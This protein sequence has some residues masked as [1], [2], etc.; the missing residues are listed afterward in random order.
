[1]TDVTRQK[2]VSS[3]TPSFIKR[4]VLSRLMTY[5]GSTHYQ[6]RLRKK[7][8]KRRL[9]ESRNHVVEY[10][11][12]VDDGYS[13]LAIQL[14]APLCSAYEID[15]IV[16]L[17]PALQDDNFP[18]PELLRELAR[19]DAMA[20]APYYNLA[21]PDSDALPTAEACNL[22][23]AIMCHLSNE[24]RIKLGPEVS[25]CL[26]RG[27]VDGLTSLAATHGSA[28]LA[29][30]QACL[31]AGTEHRA[32]L[33]HYSGAMFSYEGEWYWGVDRLH[34]LESRLAALNLRHS[35]V[36]TPLAPRR[37]LPRVYGPEASAL[38]LEFYP[39]LRS[40]YTAVAWHP[41]LQLAEQS[42]VTF[43][44]KPVLPMVMRGV[45]ATIPKAKYIFT[46]AA[47]EARSFGVDYG[48]FFD[49]IGKPVMQGYSLYMWAITQNKGNDFLGAFLDGAFANGVNTCSQRGIRRIVEG[50]GLN[51]HE[52]KAHLNDDTWQAH[53]E[54]NR[55]E[56]YGFGSWGVPSYRLLNKDGTEILGVWGQDRL[57][58]VAEKL[59]EHST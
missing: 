52:A 12:Q 34:H 19:R 57:W 16:H 58:L 24:Q 31:N 33:G 7:R 50:A 41:T 27:D 23:N 35:D 42:G 18:E 38:T 14:L 48:N 6:T 55:L 37:S 1:M 51:W 49:P 44:V 2:G 4:W 10:F 43:A 46:D 29:N 5:L 56:M 45:P 17:V 13:H 21:F 54:A 15:L 20:I 26:W 36:T 30:V 25:T 11:H 53:L 22:A 9:R 3:S 40:P 32:R 8:E 28:S 39:S 59:R 47:R